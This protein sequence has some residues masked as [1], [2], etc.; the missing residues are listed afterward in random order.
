MEIYVPGEVYTNLVK[1][2]EYRGIKLSTPPLTPDTVV[3][4]LNHYE[5]V[6]LSGTRGKE[7]SR[8]AADTTVILIAPNSKYSGKSGDFKK[9]LKYLPKVQP[10]VRLEV[11]FV[12]EY[13]LTT[14]IKKQIL[15]FKQENPDIHIE[16]YDYEIFMLENPKHVSVPPH[17]IPSEEEVSEF[18][19]LHYKDRTTFP[20]ILQSDAQA[21]W[22]GLRP[23]MVVKI[24][25]V[26]ETAGRA[27][28]YRYCVKG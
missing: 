9:L 27:I 14:H 8:G 21:V 15:A 12:S 3:Q 5:F 7:D 23:G 18:C 16:N 22:L 20:K 13:E 17:S 6:M 24:D 4:K 25:R 19:R 2:M 10:G 28:A 1:M 26:S 11:I